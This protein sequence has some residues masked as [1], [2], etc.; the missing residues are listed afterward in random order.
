MNYKNRE[1]EEFLELLKK[2]RE[3]EWFRDL[4]LEERVIELEELKEELENYQPKVAVIGEFSAGKS[5]LINSLL[6]EKILPTGFRPT[7]TKIT[8]LKFGEPNLV[9]NGEPGAID[10]SRLEGYQGEEVELYYPAP[11]LEEFQLIDTPGSNDPSF[12]NE[13]LLFQLM[14]KVDM[15]LFVINGT[16]ALKESER[17]FLS[18]LIRKK[19]ISK[20]FFILNWAD[21][22]DNPRQLKREI[23]EKLEELLEIP[24]EEGRRRVFIYSAQQVLEGER[25]ELYD[26]FIQRLRN[27]VRKKREEFFQSYLKGAIKGSAQEITLRLEGMATRLQSGDEGIIAQLKKIT[28]QMEKLQKEMEKELS[29]AE[30]ELERSKALYI[31]NIREGFRK[32][33]RE[34]ELEVAHLDYRQLTESRYLEMRVRKLVEDLVEEATTIFLRQTRRIISNLDHQMG[35]KGYQLPMELPQVRGSGKLGKVMKVGGL[36]TLVGVMGGI[37]VEV[38]SL[39]NSLPMVG[40]V[41]GFLGVSSGALIPVAGVIA[42]VSGKL[43]YSVGKWGAEKVGAVGEKLEEGAVRRRLGSQLKTQLKKIEEDI[44]S[45][46]RE[47]NF[48]NFK[49]EYIKSRFPQKEVLEMELERL[50]EAHRHSIEENREKLVE[51]LKFKE[52]LGRFR[53]V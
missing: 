20:F 40:G 52:E 28:A 15:V 13:D 36:A 49:E 18:Q 26:L 51:I 17:Q 53:D 9:V 42:L 47:I 8:T 25:R 19:D 23:V 41:L 32:I 6:G 2:Y 43:L 21:Q 50:K 34:L 14:D 46:I 30:Q 44:I 5:T 7:T 4:E 45:Q 10:W 37:G 1:L 27:Y 31:S 38:Y 35:L 22:V 48:Q 16:Q 24:Q 39:L 29:S 3:R 12:L 33:Q 11:I